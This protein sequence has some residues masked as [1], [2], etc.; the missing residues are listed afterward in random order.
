ML[1]CAFARVRARTCPAVRVI[2]RACVCVCVCVCVCECV[3]AC[4]YAPALVPV[5]TR[6]CQLAGVRV[7]RF[8][9]QPVRGQASSIARKRFLGER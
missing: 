1:G 8:E 4:V 9:G 7:G 3:C 6:A 5:L 2:L